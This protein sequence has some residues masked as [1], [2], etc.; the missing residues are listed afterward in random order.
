SFSF[1]DSSHR[2]QT[3]IFL[4]YSR[5]GRATT[6]ARGLDRRDPIFS[7]YYRPSTGRRRLRMVG[8]GVAMVASLVFLGRV[9]VND[10]NFRSS[11]G[12]STASPMTAQTTV[13]PAVRPAAAPPTVSTA[14][15]N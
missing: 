5:T 3:A 2:A 12:E 11:E 14:T 1:D 10:L 7:A 4:P 6:R 15:K 8:G 13:P 9:I